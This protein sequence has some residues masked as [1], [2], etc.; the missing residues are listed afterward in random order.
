MYIIAVFTDSKGC[1]KDVPEFSNM[2]RASKMCLTLLGVGC[3]MP[4]PECYIKS[5]YLPLKIWVP[6]FISFWASYR[7][8]TCLESWE[9]CRKSKMVDFLMGKL[10]F[11]VLK[12]DQ[13]DES[14]DPTNSCVGGH[15]RAHLSCPSPV[16][17]KLCNFRQVLRVCQM[18]IL[19]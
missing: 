6:S 18:V 11:K 15:Y 17:A 1:A 12:C 2:P 19:Y 13:N 5:K 9:L 16:T 8:Q 7:P 14:N 3:A 4:E 10:S